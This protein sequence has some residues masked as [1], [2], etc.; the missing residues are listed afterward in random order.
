MEE[1]KHKFKIMA[2]Q[3]SSKLGDKKVNSRTVRELIE[4]NIEN[5]IDL[6]VLPE[7]WT[8]GWKPDLFVDSAENLENSETIKFLSEIAI[9]YNINIIG[10]SFITVDGTNIYNTC[11]VINRAG[12]LVDIY[13]KMHLYSYYGSN[14]GS[15]L[16]P[17]K[18]P[19]IVELDGI[20]IGLTVC[21][22][23][24][25][26]EIFRAYGKAGVDMLVNCAAWGLGKELV[27]ES[28]TRT[29]AIENQCYMIAAT[30]CGQ[31]EGEDWNLGHSRIISYDGSTVGETGIGDTK[32]TSVEGVIISE[33]N[34]E[35][36]YE[37]RKKCTVFLDIHGTYDVK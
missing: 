26:P 36:M 6:I 29:R 16:T 10:G 31:I 27:W 18:K 4:S 11:P 19:V 21:Y 3:M 9:K 22:D 33:L 28:L 30:Q 14:E 24:R 37:F 25:F 13:N 17:G 34:F 2:V 20:K 32:E 5:N 23:I 8:V 15:Y 1:K 35:E 7:V 12:Q